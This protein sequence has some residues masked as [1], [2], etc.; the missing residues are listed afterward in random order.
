MGRPK[1]E[2][3]VDAPEVAE[4][5]ADI[6]Q[7]H[8]VTAPISEDALGGITVDEPEIYKP[9]EL[10]LLIKPPK[11]G[12]ENDAQAEYARHLSAYAYKNKVKWDKKKKYLLARLVEIG[13]DAEA[14][15]KYR[16]NDSKLSFKNKLIQSEED[17]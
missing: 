14:I 1:K 5:V 10:P 6:P 7:D 4:V 17:K 9:R 2:D 3:K 12:W 16:G 15:V 11:G 8:G 13:E